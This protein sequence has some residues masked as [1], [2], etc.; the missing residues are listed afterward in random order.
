MNTGIYFI[1][2]HTN[3]AQIRESFVRLDRIQAIHKNLPEH[4]PVMLCDVVQ[5]LLQSWTRV[6][7]VEEVGTVDDMLSDYRQQ[8]IAGLP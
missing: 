6:Y 1:C 3:P 4:G 2:Q 5:D 7:L 8:A